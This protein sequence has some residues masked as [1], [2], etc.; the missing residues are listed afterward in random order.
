MPIE[1]PHQEVRDAEGRT[2]AYGVAA[3][4]MHKLTAELEANRKSLALEQLIRD[5]RIAAGKAAFIAEMESLPPPTAIEIEE[6]LRNPKGIQDIIA[7][8][9][10]GSTDRHGR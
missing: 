7:M 5:R 6:S 9:E 3:E 10:Q 2:V 8:L 4:E 1:F